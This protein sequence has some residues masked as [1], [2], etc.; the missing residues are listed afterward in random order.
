MAFVYILKSL[1]TNRYYIGSTFDL[2]ERLKRHQNGLVFSTRNS[3]PWKKI[4]SQEY[5]TIT[6]AKRIELRLK[7][8]KRR[9]Y[10]EKI[11]KDGFIKIT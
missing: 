6:Q 7:K 4:F 8:L 5:S 10:I 11:I 9:D 1:K 3:R 2:D